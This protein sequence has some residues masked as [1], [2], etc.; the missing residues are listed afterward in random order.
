MAASWGYLN[1][2]GPDTWSADFPAAKGDKQTPI[3][4][5]T[6]DTKLESNLKSK[7]ISVS[8]K[9]E[10]SRKL[11]NTGHSCQV[12][13]DGEGSSL[14]GGP[15]ESDYKIEQFHFHWG[16]SNDVGSEHTIDGE[17]FAG[18][19]HLVHWDSS[20]FG[21]FAEAVDKP[22]GLCVLGIFLKIGQENEALKKLTDQFNNIK[23]PNASIDLVGG[24]DPASLLPDTERYWTY[25]GSLTTPPCFE[26]VK[27]VLFK[28]PIEISEAQLNEFRSLSS[29]DGGCMG[30]NYRPV[31]PLNDRQEVMIKNSAEYIR[32]NT[33]CIDEEETNIIREKD[34][35]VTINENKGIT[36]KKKPVVERKVS[37]FTVSSC[38]ENDKDG[39]GGSRQLLTPS[40]PQSDPVFKQFFNSPLRAE[41][42]SL[43]SSGYF[44]DPIANRSQNHKTIPPSK[45]VTSKFRQFPSNDQDCTDALANNN[46]VSF[47]N[48]ST[49]RRSSS[50][51]SEPSMAFI[52]SNQTITPHKRGTLVR[53]LRKRGLQYSERKKARLVNQDGTCNI[54]SA[55]FKKKAFI[56]DFYSS[57]LDMKWRYIWT[58]FILAFLLSWLIFAVIWYLIAF[59][60][61]DLNFQRGDN[62]TLKEDVCI[63]NVDSFTTAL[64]YS[65]ETQ[66]TIGYGGR[67]LTDKCYSAVVLLMAQTMIGVIIQALLA[68]VIIAKLSRPK[69]RKRTVLFS[70]NALITRNDDPTD[71]LKLVFRVADMRKSHLIDANIKVTLVSHKAYKNSSK[72]QLYQEP[73]NVVTSAGCDGKVF[74]AWPMYVAHT[75]N[76]NSPLYDLSEES[77]LGADL[78]II[79]VLE[80]TVPSTGML[81]QLRTSYLA[82]E[83]LWGHRF[84]PLLMESNVAIYEVDYSML[85]LTTAIEHFPSC[86]AKELSCINN[87]RLALLNPDRKPSICQAS[88]DG[89]TGFHISENI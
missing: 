35:V 33:D 31:M 74:M 22:S 24:F 86:S 38:T 81:T 11:K 83:I 49:Q 37:R 65:L 59:S 32:C 36:R 25:D 40:S 48:Y 61:G 12:V 62:T 43:D 70:K 53:K 28:E 54:R 42:G 20:R 46:N 72:Q 10:N 26:S 3:N 15:L 34:T 69:S 77:I 9:P 80:G 47:G 1:T 4:I 84:L 57:V 2:N 82:S 16:K 75:I 58:F 63:D 19:L 89:S 29:L 50:T 78:E 5:V 27:W 71:P 45:L 51:E 17:M 44:Y 56:F 79:V 55:N 7:P 30:N 23:E 66:Q 88:K 76:E 60:N 64:L 8:Y 68:G 21:S 13:I 14:K 85:D 73:L 52:S 6:G 39:D 67:A 41:R 87:K 18:E